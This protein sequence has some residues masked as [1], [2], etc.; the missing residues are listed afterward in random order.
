MLDNRRQFLVK[1]C[2]NDLRQRVA[3]KLLRPGPAAALQFFLRA[4][5]VR[6]VSPLRNWSWVFDHVRDEV[7]VS[8]DDF[9]RSLLSEVLEFFQHFVGRPEKKMDIAVRVRKFLSCEQNFSRD[10]VVFV[11]KM[12]VAGRDHWFSELLSEFVNFSVDLHQLFFAVNDFLIEHKLVIAKRLNFEIIIVICYFFYFILS[13]IGKN[14]LIQFS[15][16]AS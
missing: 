13:F 14:C 3:V 7:R 15:S 1:T 9:A 16:L 10:F 5:E 8:D 11:E 2:R 12:R 4:L 6:C